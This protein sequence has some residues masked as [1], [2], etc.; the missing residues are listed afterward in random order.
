[1]TLGCPSASKPSTVSE[2]DLED[3]LGDMGLDEESSDTHA[4]GLE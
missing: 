2:D 1:M 4:D 3:I